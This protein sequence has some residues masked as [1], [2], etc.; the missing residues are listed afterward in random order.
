M[1]KYYENKLTMYFSVRNNLEQHGLIINEMPGLNN[2]VNAFNE[3]CAEIM[4]SEEIRRVA[5][6]GKTLSKKN[7]KDKAIT[8]CMAIAA[9][10][11]SMAYDKQ[12]PELKAFSDVHRS[13]LQLIR[14]VE[15]V[16][17]LE[18][19][20]KKAQSKIDEL[21]PYGISS[22]K[23]E[24]YLYSIKG[25][26]KAFGKSQTGLGSRKFVVANIPE[27]FREADELLKII[28]KY[29]EG[30]R[31]TERE[32][33]TTYKLS[34]KIK[35]YGIRHIAKETEDTSDPGSEVQ[36]LNESDRVSF[37]EERE[38][39]K[40]G[41]GIKDAKMNLHVLINSEEDP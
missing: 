10:L 40:S 32:I 23:L 39:P 20:F 35:Y 2:R 11:Y 30:L 33:H 17:F 34:R 15:L 29:I 24:G 38:N 21:E 8:D 41:A 13:Y 25:F 6:A 14:D 27:L 1:I 22:E 3:K 7:A 26:K 31:D 12:D 19:I 9:G 36:V 28:D 18:S 37:N 16:E 4:R 5:M